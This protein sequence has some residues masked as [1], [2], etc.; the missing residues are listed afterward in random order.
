MD[1]PLDPTALFVVRGAR[2]ITQGHLGA[3]SLT[4]GTLLLDGPKR[5]RRWVESRALCYGRWSV[6]QSVGHSVEAEL[7]NYRYSP[8]MQIS[9]VTRRGQQF[10]RVGGILV[11]R[12]NSSNTCSPKAIYTI[13]RSAGTKS[14]G[15]DR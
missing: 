2:L 12:S 3:C 11:G 6:G 8:Q 9:T 13:F 15:V 1:I 14:A 5:S 10:D 7:M 4:L